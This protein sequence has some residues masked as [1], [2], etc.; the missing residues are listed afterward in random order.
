M[1]DCD[2]FVTWMAFPYV[3]G[4]AFQPIGEALFIGFEISPC[5]LE[6][7]LGIVVVGGSTKS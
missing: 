1:P 6:L 2:V 4:K 7:V 5:A 3:S